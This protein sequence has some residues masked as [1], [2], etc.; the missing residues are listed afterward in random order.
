MVI[1]THMSCTVTK[2]ML[3]NLKGWHN[4]LHFRNI[5]KIN[6]AVPHKAIVSIHDDLGN[7]MKTDYNK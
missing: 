6:V 3:K 4:Q 5:I 7:S 2:Y 1:H